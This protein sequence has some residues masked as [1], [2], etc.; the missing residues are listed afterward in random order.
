MAPNL[1][2]SPEGLMEAFEHHLVYEIN[3]FRHAYNFLRVPAWSQEM[4]NALIES[5]CVHA[6]NL[7]DFFSEYSE[8]PGQSRDYIGARHFCKDFQ[9]WTKG[10]PTDDVKNRL[11][12]QISHLT[13]DREA[14]TNRKIGPDERNELVELIEREI[15]IF[16]SHLRE[17]YTARWPFK[18]NGPVNYLMKIEE[19]P[20]TATN[21][22]ITSSGTIYKGWTGPAGPTL[23]ITTKSAE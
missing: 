23:R 21:H 5:F 19:T 16:A 11:N 3:M 20:Y 6:R 17:P 12:R 22:I 1:K 10:G 7:I 18:Q 14:A 4:A 13:Y 9:S 15:E 8:T 2:H